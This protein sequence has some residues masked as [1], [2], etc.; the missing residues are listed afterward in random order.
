VRRSQKLKAAKIKE[1]TAMNFLRLFGFQGR[2]SR[3][4]YALAGTIGVLLKH[5][6]DRFV[7]YKFFHR[8]WTVANYLAPL[9]PTAHI[10]LTGDDKKFLLIIGLLSLPFIWIGIAIFCSAGE[11]TVLS[12]FVFLA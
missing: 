8:R 5:N 1:F 12:Y 3:G 7:A 4:T 10:D 2:A 11:R 9:W 6:L